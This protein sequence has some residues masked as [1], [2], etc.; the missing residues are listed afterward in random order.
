ML[1]RG[2]QLGDTPDVVAF[3]DVAG[4][5]A[6]TD[7]GEWP[8]TY[9]HIREVVMPLCEQHGIE[10]VWIKSPIRDARSLF[11]WLSDRNQIPVA[12]PARICTRIAKVDRFEAWMNERFGAQQVAVWIGFERGEESRAAKDPNAG[13][14][15][16]Q[17]R[18]RFPLIEWDMCRCR[19]ESVVRDAGFAV[20]RK[21]ACV[22]CPYASKGDWQTL[23]SEAPELFAAVA[24]MEARKPP[25]KR[26]VKLS[27]MGFRKSAVWKGQPLP[28]NPVRGHDYKAP[29]LA[30]YVTGAYKPKRQACGICGQ[31]QRATKATGCGYLSDAEANGGAGLIQLRQSA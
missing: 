5:A 4:D 9:Q 17:R 7:P 27:I 20:P 8:G 2:I 12:G 15:S 21:S 23:A 31:A 18:N 6:G 11:A 29:T 28:Q 22:F 26:G 14:P 30:E 19:C 10:F 25:T 1:V 3:C 13:K 16:A 24:E